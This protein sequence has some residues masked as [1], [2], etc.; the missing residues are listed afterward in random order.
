MSIDRWREAILG[1]APHVIIHPDIGMNAVSAQLAAQ[2]LAAVQC[3]SWGHPDTSGY[4]TIDYFL[5]SDL[6]EPPDAQDHYTERLV[7]LPNLSIYYEPPDLQPV[8]LD[9][10]ELGL[11][12]GAIAFWCGQSLFKYLPQFDQVFARIA[13]EAGDC[14]FAFIRYG[15]G[16]TLD[17][18]FLRRLDR[19][20]ADA[21]LKASDHCVFVPRMSPQRF[22][23]AIGQCDIVLDSIGW[24]GCNSTLEGLQH[25]LPIVTM[26]GALMRGRHTMA[27][28]KRMDVE[29][30]IAQT[31]DGYVATAVRLARD[32]PWR[33]AVKDKIARNK[34]R[35]YRD[36]ECIAA[37]ETFLEDAVGRSA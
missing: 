28:L 29:D 15:Q 6:M 9:R 22:V 27:I 33:Q 31:L 20:F 10:A 12:A 34:H 24:S 21:G 37:L 36:A 3:T 19:A 13:R 25:D 2:R 16:T 7:R 14:Q 26:P 8:S 23:A 35:L 32:V 4:P 5:S 30:T 17:D 1:D 18:M 11:R